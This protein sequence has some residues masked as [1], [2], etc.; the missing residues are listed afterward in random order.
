[1]VVML[2]CGH[3]TSSDGDISGFHGPSIFSDIWVLKIDSVG[4][5]IWQKALGG[6]NGEFGYSVIESEP[7]KY[8]VTGVSASDD[9]DVSDNI[10]GE[11]FWLVKLG[12]AQSQPGMPDLDADG[13]GDLSSIPQHVNW[14]MGYAAR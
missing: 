2:I 11:D 6:T 5:I 7:G 10:G 13:Y 1:M 14:P 12:F 4:T 3:A 8:I 9:G